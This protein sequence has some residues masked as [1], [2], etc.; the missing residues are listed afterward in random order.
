MDVVEVTPEAREYIK[1]VLKKTKQNS[2]MFGIKGGGCSGFEY[3]WEIVTPEDLIKLGSE[4]YDEKV[5]L[6]E[7]YRLIVDGMAKEYITGSVIDYETSIEGSRLVV[8]NPKVK[9]SCG[10]G[11]SVNFGV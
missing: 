7:G 4:G 8:K 1:G 11:T 10:C 6:G 3:Y 9:S 2:L 5:P